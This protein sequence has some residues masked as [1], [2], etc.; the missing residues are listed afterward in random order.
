MAQTLNYDVLL[1]HNSK[2]K[3][4]V[5]AIAEALCGNGLS[6]GCYQ[7]MLK[8]GDSASAKIDDGPEQSLVLWTPALGASRAQSEDCNYRFRDLLNKERCFILVEL[9]RGALLTSSMRGGER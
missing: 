5:H 2:H 3:V 6:V 7:W 8:P 9:D 4:G 1:S